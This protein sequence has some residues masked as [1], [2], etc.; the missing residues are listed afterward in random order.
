MLF[1]VFLFTQQSC[2]GSSVVVVLWSSCL[3][4]GCRLLM[5]WLSS[6]VVVLWSSCLVSGCGLLL[7]WLSSVVVVL[8]SS[9]LFSCCRLLLSWLL[10]SVVVVLWS[11]CLVSGC[12]LLLSWLSSVV[13]VRC[14]CLSL[15]STFS[16]PQ[17]RGSGGRGHGGDQVQEEGPGEDH[18]EGGPRLHRPVRAT[19]SVHRGLCTAHKASHK[20]SDPGWRRS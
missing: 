7:S 14:S 8:W 18:E 17:G 2:F 19:G 11:S 5:S 9:C 1:S 3:V 6:V 16:S 12:R 13:V 20:A 10:S 15:T 4:S